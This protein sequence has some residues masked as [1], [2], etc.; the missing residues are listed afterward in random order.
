VETRFSRRRTRSLTVERLSDHRLV[1]APSLHDPANTWRR[2]RRHR[3]T[4]P[5]S[6]VQYVPPDHLRITLRTRQDAGHLLRWSN[7]RA[8]LRQQK[9]IS[10]SCHVSNQ[11]ELKEDRLSARRQTQ[12]VQRPHPA[13]APLSHTAELRRGSDAG[14]GLAS[15]AQVPTGKLPIRGEEQVLELLLVWKELEPARAVQLRH[16]HRRERGA[17]R[18]YLL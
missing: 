10:G 16:D 5:R 4:F 7:Q 18:A 17:L 9:S 8:I 14:R 15:V 13:V 12:P 6:A 3:D 1:S 2:W 11:V